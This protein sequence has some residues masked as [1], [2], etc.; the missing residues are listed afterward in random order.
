MDGIDY[1]IE[2]FSLMAELAR[3]LKTVSA[4]ILSHEY[5]Y[6]SFGS[7]WITLQHKGEAFRL[8]F[9]GRDYAYSIQQAIK[10]TRPHQWGEPVW[11]SRGTI[12]EI[13][14]AAI[15]SALNAATGSRSH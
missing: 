13:P 8:A 3:N 14:V 15:V 12:H 2:H 9:D 10:E 4:Q 5:S 6:E 1:P 7:W 11:Q